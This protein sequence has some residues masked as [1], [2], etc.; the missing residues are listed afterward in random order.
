MEFEILSFPDGK[1]DYQINNED[2]EETTIRL[3]KWV[4]DILQEELV[5][6]HEFIQQAYDRAAMKW[7]DLGRVKRGDVVRDWAK[8]V[9]HDKY[10]STMKKQLGWNWDDVY[11]VLDEKR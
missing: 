1:T 10:Q 4:A 6:V 8:K 3:E 11:K 7:P 2:G 5:N 9:V